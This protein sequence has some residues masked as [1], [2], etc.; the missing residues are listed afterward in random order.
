[1]RAESCARVKVRRPAHD[2]RLELAQDP[3]LVVLAELDHPRGEVGVRVLRVAPRD[4][5]VLRLPLPVRRL[6]RGAAEVVAQE[7]GHV[8]VQGRRR[9]DD[10]EASLGEGGDE[11]GLRQAERVEDRLGRGVAGGRGASRGR[12]SAAAFRPAARAAGAVEAVVPELAGRLA[13]LVLAGAALAL[14][15]AVVGVFAARMAGAAVPLLAAARDRGR[16]REPGETDWRR[17][18]HR[19]LARR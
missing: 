3:G 10:G 2:K 18:H 6:L 19:R 4:D 16:Q 8:L 14:V 11:G 1:M 12:R 9:G 17:L 13:I 15:R 5:V 7:D